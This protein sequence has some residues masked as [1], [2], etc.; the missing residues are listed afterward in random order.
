MS[1]K[2]I[3]MQMKQMAEDSKYSISQSQRTLAKGSQ[4]KRRH[5]AQFHSHTR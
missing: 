2:P 5:S 1:T 4:A 3:D